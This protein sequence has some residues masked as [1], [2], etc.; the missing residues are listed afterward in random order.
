MLLLLLQATTGVMAFQSAGVLARGVQTRLPVLAVRQCRKSPLRC[1]QGGTL[2]AENLEGGSGSL[3]SYYKFV[4]PHTVRGTILASITG[5]VRAISEQPIGFKA[6]WQWALVPRAMAG[7]LAL[8][9]G[10]AYIVGIN[11]IYDVDIDKV[12][13]VLALGVFSPQGDWFES[14]CA[15][16]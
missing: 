13:G 12:R 10:N 5:V 16:Q 6:L 2:E 15:G 11:Q 8:L 1:M 9:C 3:Q 14:R 4:R 7:M